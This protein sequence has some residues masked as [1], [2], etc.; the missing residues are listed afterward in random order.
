MARF[1]DLDSIDPNTALWILPT[2]LLR[3]DRREPPWPNH[4]FPFSAWINVDESGFPRDRLIAI[5]RW[6][7]I[8]LVGDVA[9]RFETR[10]RYNDAIVV[11]FSQRDDHQRFA[12]EFSDLI[13]MLE[14]T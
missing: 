14:D 11:A 9:V 13:F 10:D 5:R 7:E 8:N 1:I 2:E 3:Y 12:E 4:L 6:S